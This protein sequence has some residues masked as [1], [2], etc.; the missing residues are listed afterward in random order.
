MNTITR[1]VRAAERLSPKEGESLFQFDLLHLGMLADEIR[2]RRYPQNWVTFVLDRNISYTNVC[3]AGC[4]FC[5]FQVAPGSKNAFR[6][7]QA[8]VLEKVRELVEAGGTQVMI[9]GGLDPDLCLEEFEDLF[10]AIKSHY[11]VHLHSLSAPEIYHLSRRAR[12][13]PEKTLLRLRAA[14]L[15]S[16]PGG[17]AEILV[18][19]VRGTVSPGKI[20]TTQ[21][22]EVMQAAHRIGMH[23]TATMVFGLGETM[24]QRIEHLE[25]IRNLQDHTHGVK[26]FI[27]WSF[28]PA[29]TRLPRLPAGGIEY[30]K[31]VAISRI[32]L[33]NIDHI[34][35]GWVTEGPNLAQTALAFGAD[36]LGGILMEEKVVHATGVDYRLSSTQVLE[37]IRGAGRIPV[38]R[39]TRYELLKIHE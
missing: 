26:A 11:Q 19:E 38:Q 30:L 22:L 12:L 6:L 29:R 23:S 9:Q 13:S 32:Y 4:S 37:L 25:T 36:D 5:A 1:K 10:R 2:R 8:E 7:T 34:H 21:W 20:N 27:P 31:M 35:S 28:S 16:L 3:A 39:N 18:D 14:G 33:D 24:A 17:G 15:D